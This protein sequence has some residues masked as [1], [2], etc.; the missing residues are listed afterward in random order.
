MIS[1]IS[2]LRPAKYGIVVA[3]ENTDKYTLEE[4]KMPEEAV[5]A[6]NLRSCITFPNFMAYL[7]LYV[8]YLFN[9]IVIISF[10]L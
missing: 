2:L 4:L 3:F 1:K 9:L 10:L 8:I 7:L 5:K 6:A